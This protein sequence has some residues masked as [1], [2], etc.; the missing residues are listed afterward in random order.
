[1]GMDRSFFR[2][3]NRLANRTG[4]AHGLFSTFANYGVLLFAVLL[5]IAYLDGRRSDDCR[6]VAG[7]LWA[8][9]AALVALEIGQLISGAINRARPYDAMSGV[10]V[11]VDKTTEFSFPSDHATAVGAVAVGLLTINRR[12]GVVAA[13]LALLMAF[14]RIYVGAHYLTDVL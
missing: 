13:I 9:G 10:H 12:W 2:W 5:V 14:T 7:S 8:G 11:L 1:S 3:M 6:A 4:W